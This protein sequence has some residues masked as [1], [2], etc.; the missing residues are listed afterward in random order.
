VPAT[1]DRPAPMPTVE[2]LDRLPA[3]TFVASV[4]PLFEGAPT[5]LARL[6]AARP[7]GTPDAFFE[8]AEAIARA[9]PEGARIELLD[10]HPRIGAA[11]AELSALSRREQ[12]AGASVGGLTA[13]LERLNDDYE[14]RFGF[15][16]CVFVEGRSRADLVPGFREALDRDREAE[17]ARGLHDVVAIARDRYRRLAEAGR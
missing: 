8:R 16:Y 7:Y 10:A 6:A 2:V 15:R 3:A 1:L 11:P 4:A 12:R 13:E 9:M 14:A 5:F 17:L